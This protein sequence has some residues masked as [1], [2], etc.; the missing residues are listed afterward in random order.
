MELSILIDDGDDGELLMLIT[1]EEGLPKVV[2]D[3]VEADGALSVN[4]VRLLL[5]LTKQVG[6]ANCVSTVGGGRT[7]SAL[8]VSNV[9][10]RPFNC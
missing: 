9:A 2:G 1:D 7:L 10:T 4:L 3:S 6:E 8:F 5:R